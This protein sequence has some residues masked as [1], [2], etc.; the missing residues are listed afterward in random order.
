[1]AVLPEG[2][3]PNEELFG[4]DVTQLV[5]DELLNS[6]TIHCSSF[7]F[8]NGDNYYH[9]ELLV[10]TGLDTKP[11]TPAQKPGKLVAFDFI[12]HHLRPDP[13]G[14]RNPN[15]RMITEFKRRHIDLGSVFVEAEAIRNCK[16]AEFRDLGEYQENFAT[17]WHFFEALLDCGVETQV[18]HQVLFM[19]Q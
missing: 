2:M 18:I 12:S 15:Q 5:L 9:P 11:S 17:D 4:Y 8:T 6:R 16:G 3:T 7:L 19:H 14:E 10:Q 1:M 13:D